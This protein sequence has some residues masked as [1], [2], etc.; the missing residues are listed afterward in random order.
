MELYCAAEPD[1]KR[2][3]REIADIINDIRNPLDGA[4]QHDLNA[5]ESCEKVC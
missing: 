2:R 3:I 1:E 5:I 4:T